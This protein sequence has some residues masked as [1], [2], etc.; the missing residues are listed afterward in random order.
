M[1]TS[2]PEITLNINSAQNAQNPGA[3]HILVCGSMISGSASSGELI[4]DLLSESNFND[5]F[6]RT[7][8]LAKAGRAIISKLSIS[9]KRPKVSAIGLTDN[10]SGVAATGNIIFSGTA[11]A[12]GTLTI[13]IDS[14]KKGIYS[15][16][17]AASD[18]ADDIGTALAALINA[19]SDTPVTAANSSGNV[20]LT[21]KNDGTQGNTIGIKISGT[22]TGVIYT[23]NAMSGGATDPSL[24]TLFD[25]IA[26]KRYT[27]IVY[28]AEWGVSTLTDLTEARFNVDNKII[29]GQGIVA[30]TDTYANHNSALD[31][32]NLKTLCY[33]PNKKVTRASTTDLGTISSI[34]QTSG[35]ATVTCAAAHGLA[36]GFKVTVSGANE[37]EYNL[38]SAVITVTGATTFT[39]A[40][41]SGASS[42]AT[43]TISI[44]A[45][46]TT[47]SH[48]AIFE[49]P[50]VIAGVM[51]AVR[52]LRLTVGANTSS[53]VTNGQSTGGSFFGGIPYHNTPFTDF[54]IIATGDDYTDTEAAE[55]IS[56]GGW[57]LRNNPANTIVISQTAVTTYKTDALG[58]ADATFKYLNYIDS[59]SIVR[60]YIFTNWKADFSQSILTDGDLIAG[61][62][63]VNRDGFIAR[64]MG[65]YAELSGSNG[66][67]SYV[68]LRAGSANRDAFKQ[69]LTDSVILTLSTGTITA[70]LLGNIVTQLRSVIGKLTATFD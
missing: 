26:D 5:A 62:P 58:N 52:E 41:D 7:S 40:V 59:L 60:D 29:D 42:P 21:A 8:Q 1:A 65:Y 34:T 13:K 54:D 56:S 50:I 2:F 67:N 12:V 11:T 22:V 36:T 4:E 53:I 39:Y 17:V 33:I 25:V 69:S 66:S 37:S 6:G 64:T 44:V 32:L 35:T 45:N 9:K 18:T 57:L 48:G 10:A 14:S 43:G 23:I 31:A 24:T 38:S 28:P 63:M 3:R 49:S 15:L 55:L 46:I 20:T 68:L 19:N 47:A 27:S 16:S 61:R 70:D 51:A 30:K